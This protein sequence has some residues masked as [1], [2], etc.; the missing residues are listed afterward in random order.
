MNITNITAW[1]G[2]VF[3]LIA[4]YLQWNDK[5]PRLH[6]SSRVV[7]RSLPSLSDE[8]LNK[9]APVLSIYLSNPGEKPIYVK[10]V[11]LILGK[12]QEFE[13]FEYNAIYKKLT[14]P[15]TIDPLRGYDFVVDSQQLVDALKSKGYIAEVRT[16]I[17][18]YDEL[19]RSYK[20]KL[21]L[22]A[23]QLL[24]DEEV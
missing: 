18:I 11:H 6:I 22:S 19:N 8:S 5:R 24:R 2:L 4:L 12:G 15:F 9:V 20:S 23:K 3:S 7:T 17:K 10:E 21:T 13:I 1:L 16:T 14:K